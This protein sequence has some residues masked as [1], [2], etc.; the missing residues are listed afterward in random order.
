[1]DEAANTADP[2]AKEHVLTDAVEFASLF[3]STVDI[4]QYGHYT[5]YCF[6]L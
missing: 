6:I 2:L 4:T 1:V 3:N 5:N